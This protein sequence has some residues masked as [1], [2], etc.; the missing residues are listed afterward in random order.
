MYP[1][2]GVAAAAR[3]VPR[4]KGRMPNDEAR[5]A[6]ESLTG[7]E[8]VR[9]ALA[10]LRD[11]TDKEEEQDNNNEEEPSGKGD[12]NGFI[13]TQ[14]DDSEDNET[15]GGE[16]PK[17]QRASGRKAHQQTHKEPPPSPTGVTGRSTWPRTARME[18]P[19]TPRPGQD[20]H[21]RALEARHGSLTLDTSTSHQ[22]AK[23]AAHHPAYWGSGTHRRASAGEVKKDWAFKAAQA[24]DAVAW[25]QVKEASYAQKKPNHAAH[26]GGG[27]RSPPG[28]TALLGLAVL[29]GPATSSK[30][31]GKIG[32]GISAANFLL[33]TQT[34]THAAHQG[35]GTRSSQGLATLLSGAGLFGS[36]AGIFFNGIPGRA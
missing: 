30:N 33:A 26:Q 1:D 16:A 5:A 22:K 32:Q 27:T 18:K 25:V 17:V 8:V 31:K 9:R 10:A 36:N 23:E 11:D 15:S 13:I 7:A 21:N 6:L 12:N 29:F 20:R 35:G 19:G 24:E 28:R 2:D 3:F 4:A 34:P 14:D